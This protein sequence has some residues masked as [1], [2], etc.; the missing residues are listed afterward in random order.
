MHN[1]QTQNGQL[2]APETLET[3]GLGLSVS[4]GHRE[5]SC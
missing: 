4:I 2:T 1:L 3:I 5:L